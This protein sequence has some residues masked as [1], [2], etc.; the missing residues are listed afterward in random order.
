M[1]PSARASRYLLLSAAVALAAV[2]LIFALRTYRELAEMQR[3][4]LRDRAS[5]VADRLETL[6]PEQLTEPW[7]VGYAARS[8]GIASLRLFQER[9]DGDPPAVE[10]IRAGRELS[11]TEEVRWTAAR[12]FEPGCLSTP[13]NICMS[14]AS[15]WNSRAPIF[16]WR[17]RAGTCW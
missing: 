10:A 9:Q 15:T 11:R 6:P 7:R 1:L 8:P 14:S 16:C 4:Y 13:R 17:T 3:V 5:M 2:L 12:C